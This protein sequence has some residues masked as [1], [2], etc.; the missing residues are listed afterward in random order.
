MQKVLIVHNHYRIPGGEDVVAENEAKLLSDHGHKVIR[1]I[2]DNASVK[3]KLSMLFGMFFS[4][5]TYLDIRRIIRRE[6]IDIVHVHNTLFLIS[7]AVY[8][9]AVAEHVPV[10]QTMHNFRLLCPAATFYRNK[11][12]CEDCIKQG[13]G[14]ALKG[15]CY[16]NSL[17]QTAAV[18]LMNFLHLHS[19]I[20]KKVNFICLTEFNRQ[21]L[22]LL[23]RK[24]RLVDPGKIRIK[25]NF[26][27]AAKTVRMAGNENPYYLVL[28]RI[29]ALKGSSL[30]AK[31]FSKNGRRLIFAGDG[32]QKAALEH[33]IERKGID[34][35][36]CRG[37]LT[38]EEAMELLSG[39]KALIVAPQ[40]Y[41]TFGMTVIEAYSLGIP[42]IAADFG[43]PG[44][45][46]RDGITG[47]LFNNTVKGLNDAIELFETMDR[48]KMSD[49]AFW[50]YERRY[51]P[52]INYKELINIYDS[53]K[54]R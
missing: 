12:V 53:L 45:L 2:R 21:K 33:F 15:K 20:Y 47:L 5:R 22:L 26:T 28:G 17:L 43:N 46:V 48:E 44:S 30:I 31:A 51:S 8:Y 38:H 6:K 13:Y 39:A 24:K 16:R 42:V 52:E 11:H 54:S 32:D 18:M 9:A 29:E 23:N 41:E 37:Q 35:I 40:W 3:G 19:G 7:P 50:E 1:Y 27:Q 14:C 34:N 4:V 49:N 25:P 36:E 10:V